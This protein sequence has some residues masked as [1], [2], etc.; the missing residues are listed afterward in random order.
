M[1]SFIVS[2]AKLELQQALRGD[3]FGAGTAFFNA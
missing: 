1:N 2:S 3:Y